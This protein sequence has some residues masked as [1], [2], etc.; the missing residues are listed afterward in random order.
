M[1]FTITTRYN[2]AAGDSFLL[3][4]TPSNSFIVSPVTWQ[5]KN[6]IVLREGHSIGSA[7]NTDNDPRDRCV[8]ERTR[9]SSAGNRS[10]GQ[11]RRRPSESRRWMFVRNWRTPRVTNSLSS[12]YILDGGFGLWKQNF[13]LLLNMRSNL[14]EV[15]SMM[16]V[17]GVNSSCID[18]GGE[19]RNGAKSAHG[20]D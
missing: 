14:G 17:I 20:L 8:P 16:V 9:A 15:W 2:R 4:N 12:S 10:N 1:E 5:S 19:G 18:V 13:P 11:D 6:A 7:A 3:V